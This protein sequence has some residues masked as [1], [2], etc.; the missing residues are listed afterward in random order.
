MTR[1]G[2]NTVW[3]ARPHVQPLN[4]SCRHQLILPDGNTFMARRGVLR[5]SQTF[6]PLINNAYITRLIRP[7]MCHPV[8]RSVSL[9][10]CPPL[11]EQRGIIYIK[12]GAYMYPITRVI[13]WHVQRVKYSKLVVNLD[14]E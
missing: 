9:T 8:M 10:Q 14:K 12:N 4:S 6:L 1:L 3:R 7:V 5:G 13:S 11:L 2:D